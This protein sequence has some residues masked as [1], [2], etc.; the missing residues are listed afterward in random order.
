[1]VTQKDYLKWGEVRL[2]W[3]VIENFLAMPMIFIFIL[4]QMWL[5]AIVF[6]GATLLDSIFFVYHMRKIMRKAG[7]EAW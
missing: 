2:K 5:W 6:A 4:L 7:M 1:M 3:Y